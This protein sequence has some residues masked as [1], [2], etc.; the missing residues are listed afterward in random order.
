MLIEKG[1]VFV[2]QKVVDKCSSKVDKNDKIELKE[3]GFYVSRGAYKLLGAIEKFNLNFAGK[4]VLDMGASTGGFTEVALNSS[5]KKVYAVDVGRGELAP[6][7][8]SDGRVKNLEGRDI[9][10][11]LPSE[12]GDADIIIGDLSF[13]SLKLILPKIKE[14]LPKNELILLFKPQFECG[15]DIARKFKGVIKDKK[16]HANLLNNF[17]IW[18]RQEGFTISGITYSPIKGKEGNIE[19][20]LHL[21]GKESVE[22]DIEKIVEEAF[23]RLNKMA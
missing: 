9:R 14:I 21:N 8:A 15:K 10:S 23:I 6:K 16:I 4:V 2:N 20:L 22:V 3:W 11:L 1:C 17:V 19:Y 12:V 7:L 5:A 18:L 13:I